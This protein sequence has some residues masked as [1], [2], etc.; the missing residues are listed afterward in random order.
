MGEGRRRVQKPA[1]R[2]SEEIFFFFLFFG[3]GD[4][5]SWLWMSIFLSFVLR[6]VPCF[7]RCSKKLYETA[8]SP[9]SFPR[10][11]KIKVVLDLARLRLGFSS[12]FVLGFKC[13]FESILL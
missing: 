8:C 12:Q 10:I 4:V 13:G 3:D 6:I 1:T 5:N 2:R 11:D 9:G 7:G